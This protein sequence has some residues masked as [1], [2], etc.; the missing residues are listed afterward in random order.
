[1]AGVC[2]VHCLLAPL[3]IALLPILA[4]SFFVH[5]DFH[6]WMLL[7]VIPTTGFAIF[8]GCRRHKDRLVLACGAVGLSL[9]ILA[10]AQE[11]T[12]HVAALEGG[13]SD[14]PVCAHCAAD[15][16]LG[17]WAWVNT[18][19]GVFLA[20]AHARNFR[21]CRKSACTHSA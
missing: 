6:L 18:L 12:A 14:A 21:L 17:A 16:P 7:V 10:L 11:R 15:A 13:R 20:G 3:L 19:G 1:M 2:A 9:L 8:M 5:E 4:T